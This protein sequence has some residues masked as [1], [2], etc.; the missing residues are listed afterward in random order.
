MINKG[1][2][3]FRGNYRYVMKLVVM[4]KSLLVI[5]GDRLQEIV[6]NV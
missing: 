6:E 4:Q 2:L 5:V 3:R 1:A